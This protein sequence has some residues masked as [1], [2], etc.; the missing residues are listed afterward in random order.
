M[1]EEFTIVT[2]APAVPASLLARIRADPARAPEHIALAAAERHGPAARDW[3]AAQRGEDPRKLARKAKRTH[4]R[5][6][7]VTGA[8]TGVG[9]VITMLPDVI[10]AVWIQSRMVFFVAAAY[11]YD[12][13]DRMRSAELLVLYELYEHPGEAREALDGAGR[14]LA[15][16]A[17]AKAMS[18]GEQETLVSRLTRMLVRRGTS[19]LAGRAIPG[20][21]I[22]VNSIG[23]ER[24][25]RELA[26]RAIDFYGG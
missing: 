15:V 12:P 24:S 23:N 17:A 8:A 19:R 20:V 13:L 5:Y 26:D 9:G 2:D 11:G 16:A 3:V 21:A 6:A 22:V 18:R 25:L 10:A 4:A 1:W 14:T 7:R